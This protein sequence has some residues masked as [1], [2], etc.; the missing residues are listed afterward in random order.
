MEENQANF[1][2]YVYQD[3]KLKTLLAVDCSLEKNQESWEKRKNDD[4]IKIL[5]DLNLKNVFDENQHPFSLFYEPIKNVLDI[6]QKFDDTWKIPVYGFGA[7]L[8]PLF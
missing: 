1:V 8:G 2:S 4:F 7:K 5:E 3:F 6:L